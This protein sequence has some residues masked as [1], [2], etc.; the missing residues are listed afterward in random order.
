MSR[1]VFSPKSLL[2]R[3]LWIYKLICSSISHFY[4]NYSAARHESQK[5]KKTLKNHLP[6][7]NPLNFSVMAHSKSSTKG[8]CM[9]TRVKVRITT[10]VTK[11]IVRNAYWWKNFIMPLPLS[12]LL[13]SI[14]SK[15]IFSKPKFGSG[16]HA[17]HDHSTHTVD[18]P[19]VVTKVT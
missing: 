17:G 7:P 5:K 11:H 1:V 12:K 2:G 9:E 14:Q 6:F 3:V 8:F 15:P 18:L 16:T 4:L 19:C 13:D 10:F